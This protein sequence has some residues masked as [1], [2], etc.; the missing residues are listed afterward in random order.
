[1]DQGTIDL[2]FEAGRRLKVDE[3]DCIRCSYG[4]VLICGGSH[5]LSLERSM[6]SY[7]YAYGGAVVVR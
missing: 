3:S 1:M 4:L 5:D 7:A 6:A 2:G